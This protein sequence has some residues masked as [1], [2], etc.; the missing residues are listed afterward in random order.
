MRTIFGGVAGS[1]GAPSLSSRLS[2]SSRRQ[3]FRRA[4]RKWLAGLLLN[5]PL[6]LL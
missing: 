6:E 4:R 5:P 3:L 2:L 1:S